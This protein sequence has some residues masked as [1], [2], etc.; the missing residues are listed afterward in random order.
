MFAAATAALLIGSCSRTDTEANVRQALDDANIPTVEVH[1]NDDSIVHLVGTVGTLA[2][3]TRAEEVA[4]AAV[5]TTGRVVNEL[6]VEA[7][8]APPDDPDEVL[9][10]VL[11]RLIDKDPVLR[12]RDVNIGVANGAVVITGEVST[13][14]ERERVGALLRGAPGVGSLTNQLQ[15]HTDH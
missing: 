12:E 2:D 11:D 8:E 9:T 5:G 10:R 14:A 13:A 6:T 3:R 1:V 7:L 15:V 4:A